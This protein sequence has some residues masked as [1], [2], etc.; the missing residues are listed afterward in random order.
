MSCANCHSGIGQPCACCPRNGRGAV[1]PKAPVNASPQANG[2]HGTHHSGG[3][4]L[5]GTTDGMAFHRDR[6]GESANKESVDA[7]SRQSVAELKSHT[8]NESG[9]VAMRRNKVR[10]TQAQDALS[11]DEL[12]KVVGGA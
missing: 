7:A 2:N 10:L 1:P 9:D 11:L 6:K 8:G 3:F 5:N 4:A 12:D